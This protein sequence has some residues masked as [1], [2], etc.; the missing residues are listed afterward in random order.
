MAGNQVA[1]KA[2]GFE[3]F[4]NFSIDSLSSAK[5]T[6]D[7]LLGKGEMMGEIECIGTN[8]LAKIASAINRIDSEILAAE[9]NSLSNEIALGR[10]VSSDMALETTNHAKQ[11]LKM[12]MA[13]FVMNNTTRINDILAPLTTNH[14]RSELMN[15]NALL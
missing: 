5:E 8:W 3:T 6:S 12:D 11:M 4:E 10:I 2:V 1:L 15:G 14:H 13:A 7:K 9:S